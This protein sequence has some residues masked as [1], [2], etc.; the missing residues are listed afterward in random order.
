GAWARLWCSL[1][2]PADRRPSLNSVVFDGSDLSAMATMDD[3]KLEDPSWDGDE[4]RVPGLT[5]AI[6]TLTSMHGHDDLS[7]HHGDHSKWHWALLGDLHE[8]LTE[9]L[10]DYEDPRPV[11]EQVRVELEKWSRITKSPPP[12]QPLYGPDQEAFIIRSEEHTSELQSR[13]DLVCRLL[14]EKKNL[15]NKTHSV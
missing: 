7:D 6:E 11:A 10:S 8:R 5:D 1:A 2:A 13:F 15:T 3:A 12:P 4:V 9:H 14:L